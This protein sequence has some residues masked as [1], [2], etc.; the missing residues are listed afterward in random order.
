MSRRIT[1]TKSRH[2]EDSE[3]GLTSQKI[4]FSIKDFFSK[5][6]RIRRKLQ[7]WSHLPKK[8]LMENFIFCAV[9][10]LLL[11]TTLKAN[12]GGGVVKILKKNLRVRKFLFW[13]GIILLKGLT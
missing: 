12:R 5:C 11:E 1:V 7:I 9:S 4:E 6:Y 2:Q 10:V 3:A 8:F 13:W